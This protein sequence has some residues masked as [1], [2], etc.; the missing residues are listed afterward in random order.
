MGSRVVNPA[1]IG[2]AERAF[3]LAE[4]GRFATLQAVIRQLRAEGYPT[5]LTDLRSRH[6]RRGLRELCATSSQQVAIGVTS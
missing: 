5:V 1:R 4:S 3:E 6:L 2:A